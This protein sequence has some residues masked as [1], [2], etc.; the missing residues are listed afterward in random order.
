MRIAAFRNLAIILGIA[1]LLAFA[2]GGGT[3]TATILAAVSLIFLAAAVWVASLLYR[4]HRGSLYLLGERRRA[5]LYLA[6]T[7]LAVTL[8]AT[9]RLWQTPAGELVWLV[10]VAGTVYTGAAVVWVAR[11]YP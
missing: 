6:A 9:H 2:P 1:A 11:R 7:I 8:T 4:E 10:L 5:I 3:A